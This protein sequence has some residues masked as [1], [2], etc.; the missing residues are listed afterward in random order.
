VNKKP[1]DFHPKAF[2]ESRAVPMD[3]LSVLLKLQNPNS[4]MAD[5]YFVIGLEGNLS[6]FWMQRFCQK[7]GNA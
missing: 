2:K 4:F 3:G 1:P 7:Q 5:L 6:R